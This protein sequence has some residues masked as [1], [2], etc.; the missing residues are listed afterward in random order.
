MF[1]SFMG[2][3]RRK[4]AVP[5]EGT[6]I[7][8]TLLNQLEDLDEISTRHFA[9][10]RTRTVQLETATVNLEELADYLIEASVF[11]SKGNAFPSRW[12]DRVLQYEN[13]TLE[14]FI[15][16]ANDL[17]HPFD[18]LIAHR[19]YIVKLLDAFLQMDSADRDYY[20]RKCNFVIEDLLALAKASRECLR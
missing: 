13:R 10:P 9:V 16:E 4:E 15:T 20:Q 3:L 14:T 6:T 19:L 12:Q 11:V 18:W 7:Y 5:L 17:I 1:K 2:W 8:E